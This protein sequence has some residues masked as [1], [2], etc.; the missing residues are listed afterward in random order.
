MAFSK[1]LREEKISTKEKKNTT[2]RIQQKTIIEYITA[3]EETDVFSL[4]FYLYFVGLRISE[5]C[6]LKRQDVDLVD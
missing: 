6:Q 2:K 5:I 3:I 4:A 1:N